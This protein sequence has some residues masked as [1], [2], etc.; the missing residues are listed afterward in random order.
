MN[1]G[2]AITEDHIR[3]INRKWAGLG[4][5]YHNGLWGRGYAQGL[6]LD[7][8]FGRRVGQHFGMRVHGTLVHPPVGTGGIYDPVIN[9]GL[10]LFGRGPVWLGI[11]RAYGGGGAWLGIRPNPTGEGKDYQFTGGGHLGVEVIVAPRMSFTIEIGG[12][13]PGHGL[14]NDDAGASVMGGFMVYLGDIGRQR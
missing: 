13:G 2:P 4:L 1:I 7:I 10:E 6:K 12:Q 9:T 3:D 14:R 11:L 8:P 5:G